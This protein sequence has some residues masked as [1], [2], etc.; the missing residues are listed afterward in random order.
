MCDK[1]K[2]GFLTP[3]ELIVSL[4][5]IDSKKTKMNQELPKIV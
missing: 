1:G 3:G 2:K 4:H 5:L